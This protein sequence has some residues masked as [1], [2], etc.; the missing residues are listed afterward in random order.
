MMKVYAFYQY[1]RLMHQNVLRKK[2]FF[3]HDIRQQIFK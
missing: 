1:R 3:I 2:L